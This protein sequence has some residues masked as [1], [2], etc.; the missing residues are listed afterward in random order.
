MGLAS[1]GSNNVTG[2]LVYERN[3]AAEEARTQ[4]NERSI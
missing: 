4:E 1:T 3:K 2:G